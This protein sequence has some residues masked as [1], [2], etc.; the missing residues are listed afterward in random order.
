MLD[1]HAAALRSLSPLD[2]SLIIDHF[3]QSD[4]TQLHQAE[5][6]L[7]L[8]KLERL[9]AVE[10]LIGKAIQRLPPVVMR[11][12]PVCPV[13]E[14]PA[15]DLRKVTRVS[16]NPRLPTTPSFQ[17]FRQIVPGRTV[18]QLL[19]RGVTRKDLREALNNGWMELT[20]LNV[21]KV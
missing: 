1:H 9:G 6:V 8:L 14:T 18:S 19:K 4:P 7:L 11:P 15:A 16:R 5:V 12:W 10:L 17:R 2:Q 21:E 13:S 3:Q 20:P